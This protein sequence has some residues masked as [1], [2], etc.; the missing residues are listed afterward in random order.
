MNWIAWD[1]KSYGGALLGG[2]VG[3]FLFGALLA[4]GWYAPWL[5][6]VLMGFGCAAITLERSTMRG[7]VL[8]IGAAWI[9]AAA[10][11]HYQPPAGSDGLFSGLMHF[12]ETLSGSAL[13]AHLGSMLA[14]FVIGR[15][16]FRRGAKRRLAGA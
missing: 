10:Q 8:A 1:P 14:A 12:H 4:Q 6:G 13:W 2:I 16:S 7:L 9:A 5:V 15:L 3:F 11:V